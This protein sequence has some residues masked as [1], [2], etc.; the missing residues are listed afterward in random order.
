[1]EETSKVHP[2]NANGVKN[3]RRTGKGRVMLEKAAAVLQYNDV[4]S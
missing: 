1:M 3:G 4:G 2:R